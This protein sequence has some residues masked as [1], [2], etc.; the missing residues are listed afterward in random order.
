MVS[1]FRLTGIIHLSVEPDRYF[2][3]LV[4]FAAARC[5]FHYDYP[6]ENDN[7][8]DKKEA[9]PN[10]CAACVESVCILLTPVSYVVGIIRS[11]FFMLQNV[12][13]AVSKTTK[14]TD[15][16]GCFSTFNSC[17]DLFAGFDTQKITE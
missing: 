2:H 4:C 17:F 16:S 13:K 6:V 15:I 7:H 12:A 11:I 5:R 3:S 9:S 8:A 14:S 10:S 1:S